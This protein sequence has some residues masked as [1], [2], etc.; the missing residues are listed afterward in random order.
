MLQAVKAYS[1]RFMQEDFTPVCLLK[2]LMVTQGTTSVSIFS[3]SEE[4]GYRSTV[5]MGG[6]CLYSPSSCSEEAAL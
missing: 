5:D 3:I 6:G 4:G 1:A 2:G